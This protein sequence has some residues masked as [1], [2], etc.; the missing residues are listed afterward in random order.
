MCYRNSKL[1][2]VIMLGTCLKEIGV[3]NDVSYYFSQYHIPHL[4]AKHNIIL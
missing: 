3:Q 1:T 4:T 2:E